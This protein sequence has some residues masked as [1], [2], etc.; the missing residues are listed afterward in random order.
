M[1]KETLKEIA[2]KINAYC[3]ENN[4][5]TIRLRVVRILSNRDINI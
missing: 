5:T 2:E 3:I 4:I 1:K